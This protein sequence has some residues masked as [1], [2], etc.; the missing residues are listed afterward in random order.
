MINCEFE[1]TG[2]QRWRMKL[3]GHGVVTAR[4]V[5]GWLCCE[6]PASFAPDPVPLLRRIATLPQ[7]LKFAPARSGGVC[8]RVELP[9]MDDG[10][11]DA[12]LRF[13]AA[14]YAQYAGA[15][16]PEVCEAMDAAKL[17]ALCNEAGWPATIRG[18]ECRVPLHFDDRRP[19]V[20]RVEGGLCAFVDVVTPDAEH[21][22]CVAAAALLLFRAGGFVRLARPVL[23]DGVA[24]FEAFVPG[25]VSA[26]NIVPG[27]SALSVA[28]ECCTR[29][30]EA[31]GGDEA[32][33][34]EYLANGGS[35]VLGITTTTTT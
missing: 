8:L 30:A 19:A 10:E 9:V 17:A 15:P 21:P 20:V 2:N 4:L 16:R 18:A 6:A 33:A 31:L 3:P 28:L 27:L 25:P 7:P 5:D 34:T 29:E 24:R 22:A 1:T 23:V 32:L 12:S 11:V 13:L 35:A 26:E 14:S